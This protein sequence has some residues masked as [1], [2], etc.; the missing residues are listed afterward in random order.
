MESPILKESNQLH[1][2]D[3]MLQFEIEEN[4]KYLFSI[5]C[6]YWE[7]LQVVGKFSTISFPIIDLRGGA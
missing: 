4:I 6:G 1:S 5:D 7:W 2:S 3:I